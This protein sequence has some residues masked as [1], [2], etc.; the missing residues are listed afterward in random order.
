MLAQGREAMRGGGPDRSC[1]A[2]LVRSAAWSERARRATPSR[3]YRRRLD[4]AG[5]ALVAAGFVLEPD[6]A[7]LAERAVAFYDR[8]LAR[9]AADV[10]CDCMLGD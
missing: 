3:D 5:H 4:A 8:V 2:T 1:H 9:R 6:L 10:S 7:A